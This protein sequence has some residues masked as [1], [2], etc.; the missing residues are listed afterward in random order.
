LNKLRFGYWL[1]GLGYCVKGKA[2]TLI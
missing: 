1:D 2:S